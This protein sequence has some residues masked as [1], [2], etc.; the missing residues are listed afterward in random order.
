M[1][2]AEMDGKPVKKLAV[3]VEATANLSEPVS[4]RP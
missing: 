2:D 1:G 4:R 3:V